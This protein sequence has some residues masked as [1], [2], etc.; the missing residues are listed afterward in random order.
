MKKWFLM[1]LTAALL[2]IGCSKF[3]NPPKLVVFISV[4]QGMP[5]LLEKYAHLFTGGYRWLK[6]NGVQFSQTY[7]EHGY[8]STGPGHFVLS[9]G[10]HPGKGGL[11]TNH[12]YDRDSRQGWYCVQD[13][14]A[15][16]LLDGSPGPSYKY[17]DSSTLGDWLKK[18]NPKSKVVSVAGKDR[19]A[20]L[21]GGKNPDLVLWYDKQGGW[22]SSTYYSSTLPKW[23][24]SFNDKLNIGSYVDSVWNRITD[25][26]IYVSNTRADYYRGEAD[27]TP[28]KGYSPT[29]PIEFR[30]MGTEAITSSFAYTPFGDKVVLNLGLNAVNEYQ[31][32]QD[33]NPD[34]LF[35]GLSATDGVGHEFGAHSHEQ[36]DNY[37]RL[38]RNLGEFIQSLENSVGS[39]N[40]LYVLSSDHGAFG[41][42]EYLQA[43]GIE[44]G[45]IPEPQ[46]DS[47][48]TVVKDKITKQI[49]PNKVIRFENLFYY[50]KSL[51]SLEREVATDILKSHLSKLE[52]IRT[53][54]TRED[55][56][57]GGKSTY[58]QRL[59]NMVHPEK[60]PDIYLI[61][62]KYWT[63]KYPYG[64]SHGSPYDYDA[65]VPLI[66]SRNGK[67]AN[68]KSK[69]VKTVDIAPTIAKILN[70]SIPNPVDGKA[71]SID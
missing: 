19:A 34:I 28:A 8:T 25:E 2:F 44:A 36:L 3:A 7:H 1:P 10:M 12:W 46:R 70:I 69:R 53:V 60:S 37:L 35:L 40:V 55:M 31:L 54:I 57:K 5:E 68:I 22:T 26:D 13:T 39:G 52:G 56:L 14:T 32:G 66:F 21:L 63:W 43:Q 50:N 16:V 62:K 17:I 4:D 64:A 47:L 23:V 41:L 49:G 61:P 45:R 11:I 20:V 58:Q 71:L 6:D 65:H 30:E 38:D 15:T 48:Y 42:P 33:D 18:S 24:S 67:K 29:F 59:K 9:S 27:W 51:N